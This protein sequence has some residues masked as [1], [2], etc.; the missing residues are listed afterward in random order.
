MAK[1]D[2]NRNTRSDTLAYTLHP[3]GQYCKK[4]RGKLYYFE[5]DKQLALQGYLQQATYLHNGK[6]LRPGTESDTVCLRA[7]CNLY[8][9]HQE[10]R[11][12]VG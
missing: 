6:C 2:S 5:T 12:M 1:R 4:A 8:L 11:V 10:S 9:D 7:L 3:T